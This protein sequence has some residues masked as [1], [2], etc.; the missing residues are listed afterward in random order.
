MCNVDWLIA[1]RVDFELVTEAMEDEGIAQTLK[2][3]F[4]DI[5][6][7][8]AHQ[9]A[10]DKHWPPSQ[11]V[12]AVSAAVR[13]NFDLASFI[14]H[15]V[16]DERAN[17]P[18]GRLEKCVSWI[19]ACGVPRR[20]DPLHTLHFLYRRFLSE[21]PP[22][23]HTALLLVGIHILY[24]MLDASEVLGILDLDKKPLY[25]LF[26]G[27]QPLTHVSDPSRRTPLFSIR[28]TSFKPLFLDVRRSGALF[29]HD[30][31]THYAVATWALKTISISHAIGKDS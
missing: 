5:R 12:D 27:L 23:L 31:Q 19:H 29:H 16:A 10:T 22:E 4:A 11:L 25:R 21:I 26:K 18:R 9:L 30:G 20:K 13:E 2:Q 8:F 28:H 17:D 7:I 15:F 24:P 6:R 14:L 3:G 1:D